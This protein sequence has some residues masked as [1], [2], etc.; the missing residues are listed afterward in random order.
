MVRTL[1]PGA[2]LALERMNGDLNTVVA[3]AC[4]L[5]NAYDCVDL[6]VILLKAVAGALRAFSADGAERDAAWEQFVALVDELLRHR[7]QFRPSVDK[8]SSARLQA[9]VT[10]NAD[11][12][13]RQPSHIVAPRQV[14]RRTTGCR[15]RQESRCYNA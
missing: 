5:G 10:E 6:R 15:G 12:F 4:E 1:N 13:E 7:S 14:H 2:F 11:V 8:A 9:F 3:A